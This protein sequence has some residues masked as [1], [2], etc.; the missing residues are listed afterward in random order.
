[1]PD[2][3][4]LKAVN[5]TTFITDNTCDILRPEKLIKIK[6]IGRVTQ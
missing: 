1:M 4:Q 3:L 2:Y 5:G 6:Y